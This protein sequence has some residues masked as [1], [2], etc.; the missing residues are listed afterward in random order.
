MPHEQLDRLTADYWDFT[1]ES[2]PSWAT[3]IGDHR[4]DHLIE[5]HS[6][7]ADARRRQALV[8][9][10]GRLEQIDLGSLDRD[11]IVTARILANE[12]DDEIRLIDLAVV[13]LRSDQMMGPHMEALIAA[14]QMAAETPDHAEAL[15]ERYAALASSL[16]GAGERFRAGA[17]RGRTPAALCLRRSINSIDGYLSTSLDD[18]LFVNLAGPADWSGEGAWRERLRTIVSDSVRPGFL[19]M[20]DL[21]ADELMP[22][23]RDDEHAGLCWIDDGPEIYA[24]L[25]RLY[26]SLPV[27]PDE[28]HDFGVEQS[29]RYLPQRY[30]EIGAGAF[31]TSDVSAVFDRLRT[32]PDVRFRSADEIVDL[33]RSSVARATSAMSEWFGR[34]PVAGC[35]VEP[36]PPVLAADAPPAYYFPPTQDGSRPGTYFVNL[37]HPEEQSRYEAEAIAFHEAIPGHHLQLAIA[38]ELDHLPAFRRMGAGNTAYIEGWGLYAERL[39]DE[40]GLYSSDVDRLGM[41]AADSWRS[42]RLVVD[43]GLHA[44]GWSRQRAIDYLAETSPVPV[45]EIEP[46]IDRYVAMPGQAV[47]YKVGQRE[48][49]RQ[50]ER[51]K[52][53]LGER[54]DIAA[55]HDVVLG[56]GGVI[57]PVLDELV[58]DW[59]ATVHRD[60]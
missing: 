37:R 24:A 50:R 58:G 32:D 11:G 30:A 19:R 40:M 46:E 7:D 57:L 34:L 28:L 35:R 23:A 36:V 15:L 20:R 54:F 38:T 8:G 18:D 60:S 22:V 5:D 59:I 55:F 41:L 51:A 27:T 14:P 9:F 3:L 13:E 26:T 1:M 25:L 17:A 31:G 48:I 53:A 21:L 4:F 42:G 39:A 6:E 29:E 2:A 52:E 16:D 56:S 47:A 49:F 33:A 44:K 10:A 12:I 45:S 43:T